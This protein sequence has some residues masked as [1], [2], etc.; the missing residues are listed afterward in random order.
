[1]SDHTP[2][3]WTKWVGHAEVYANVGKNT[4][5]SIGGAN[6]EPMPCIA[7]CDIEVDSFGDEDAEGMDPDE[8]DANACL[9]AAA[10]DLLE[11]CETQRTALDLCIRYFLGKGP[12][13]DPEAL[14][15]A[16]IRGGSAIAKAGGES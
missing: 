11:A 3:P 12:Q 13:P 5:A 1:M 9:I 4:R 16:E 14:A 2:G 6:K 15:L 10:P 8:A 7:R